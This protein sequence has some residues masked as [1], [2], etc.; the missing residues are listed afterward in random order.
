MRR[1][2]ADLL[3]KPVAPN[4]VPIDLLP[5]NG[6]LPPQ[7][8][9]RTLTKESKRIIQLLLVLLFLFRDGLHH[10]C[11]AAAG[12]LDV[13]RMSGKQS[14]I[15]VFVVVDVYFQLA[16]E[17]VRG[18]VEVVDAPPAAVPVV[19]GAVFVAG[20]YECDGRVIVGGVCAV[21]GEGRVVLG[22][23]RRQGFEE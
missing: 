5:G 8:L 22:N 11:G 7:T 14:H 17:S 20:Y 15:A 12:N 18:R 6:E 19:R 16:S 4:L 13:D 2:Q 23:V 9:E 10:V 21:G 3:S 1:K